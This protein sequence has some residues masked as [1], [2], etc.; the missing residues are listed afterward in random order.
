[1]E[2]TYG[3]LQAPA[4]NSINKLRGFGLFSAGPERPIK[5]G[6]L[7]LAVNF[8]PYCTQPAA[9]GPTSCTILPLASRFDTIRALP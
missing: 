9:L 4:T 6:K 5:A 7:C 1:M 8:S 2:G 3:W